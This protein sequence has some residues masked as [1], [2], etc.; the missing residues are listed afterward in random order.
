MPF[1][2]TKSEQ[3]AIAEALS[4]AD[5]LI[6][7]LE[8][9]I[10]KKH[11]VKQG[12]MQE[13]LTGKTRLPGFSGQWE[14]KQLADL[15]TTFGGLTGKTKSDF[16][17]GSARYITFMNVIIITI[18]NT[19]IITNIVNVIIIIIIGIIIISIGI[20]IINTI[21]WVYSP[22]LGLFPGCFGGVGAEGAKKILGF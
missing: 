10:A 7:S 12:T 4:D 2:P 5:A 19:D 13:L 3:Q 20:I 11:Q 17:Q 6:Q 18:T 14:I 21:P 8:Q 1:P 16:G 22:P 9:L 15:G